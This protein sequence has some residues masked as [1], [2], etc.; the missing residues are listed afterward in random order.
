MIVV[1]YSLSWSILSLPSIYPLI[2]EPIENQMDTDIICAGF[3]VWSRFVPLS[4]VLQIGEIGI[5]DSSCFHLYRIQDRI[6]NELHFLIIECVNFEQKTIKK[7]FQFLGSDGSQFQ[8]EISINEASYKFIWYFQGFITIPSQ[9]QVSI[10]LYE[11]MSQNF[12]QQIQIHFP[13]EGTNYNLII[14]GHFKV[15]QNSSLYTYENRLLSFFPGQM[16]Y[17]LDFFTDKPEN[18]LDIIEQNNENQCYCQNSAK[19]EIEDIIIQ[20]QDQFQFYLNNL[21]N[22][23]INL[24]SDEFYYQL[25]KL[26]GNFQ[27]IID[28]RQFQL[29]YKIS[30]LGNQI[31]IKSYSY[32][33]PT[34]NID[35]SKNPFL[36]TQKFDINCDIQLWHYILIE[37]TETSISISI[38]FYQG[39]DQEQF[40]LNILVNHF[41]MVQFKLLYGNTLKSK[42]DY[43]II[44]IIGFKFLNCPDINQPNNNCHLTCKECDGPTKEDCLSC[45]ELSNRRYLP[46]FKECICQYGTIDSN[47]ECINYQNLN[48]NLVQEQELKTVCQYGFFNS[49]MNTI[50]VHLQLIKILLHVWNVYKIL[51][52]GFRLF[53]VKQYYGQIRTETHQ[54]IFKHIINYIIFQQEM[55]YNTVLIVIQQVHLIVKL[56]I[57]NNYFN[58]NNYAN[59]YCKQIYS[60]QFILLY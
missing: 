13:L 38:T 45:F 42:S 31:I 55:I 35:F 19:T 23:K 3:G 48:L 50:N 41:N 8:Q 44:Q 9:K 34:V 58:L 1:Q 30:S 40:N 2:I 43:L 46:D 24:Y 60:I 36:K 57:Q 15:S 51:V 21:I 25:F 32:T 11:Q 29:L 33:F 16:I 20:Q 52:Y 54:N 12:S 22:I 17:P 6:N 26:S 14:V 56:I 27:F 49:M 4:Y 28:I 18:F 39:F 37:K 7:Y 10:Y 47:N 53:F 5:L 59:Q